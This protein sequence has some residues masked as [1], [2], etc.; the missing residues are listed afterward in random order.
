M[1]GCPILAPLTCQ[2]SLTCASQEQQ[3]QPEKLVVCVWGEVLLLRYLQPFKIWNLQ[4]PEEDAN[5]LGVPIGQER[6][7][8]GKEDHFSSFLLEDNGSSSVGLQLPRQLHLKG[9]LT[10]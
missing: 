8:V 1:S 2:G 7:V 3:T 9:Q 5:T 10:E 4:G 6:R